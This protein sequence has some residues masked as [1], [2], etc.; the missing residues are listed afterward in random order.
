MEM[1]IDPTWCPDLANLVEELVVHIFEFL[2]PKEIYIS[3]M[4]C[5][6]FREIAKTPKLAL[7]SKFKRALI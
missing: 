7:V 1:E 5:K 2:A 4:T 6:R 3:S